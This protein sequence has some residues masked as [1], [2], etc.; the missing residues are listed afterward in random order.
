[1]SFACHSKAVFHLLAVIRM[2]KKLIKFKI[3]AT[4]LYTKMMIPKPRPYK[5]LIRPIRK[6]HTILTNS[7]TREALP[8]NWMAAV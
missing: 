8:S 5:K 1:M 7:S 6:F 2:M 4:M 3:P